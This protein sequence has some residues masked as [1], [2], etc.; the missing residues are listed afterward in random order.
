MRLTLPV[1]TIFNAQ[2]RDVCIL[3]VYLQ[4]RPHKELIEHP[5]LCSGCSGSWESPNS[6][7]ANLLNDA[8]GRRLTISVTT[9]QLLGELTVHEEREGFS[10][11]VDSEH[12]SDPKM[13]KLSLNLRVVIRLK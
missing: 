2:T 4:H 8:T 3:F 7:K 10:S 6:K 11:F 13:I 12:K 5:S 1:V 9:A